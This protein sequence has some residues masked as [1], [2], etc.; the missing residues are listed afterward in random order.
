[1]IWRRLAN[2]VPLDN[3]RRAVRGALKIRPG[4]IAELKRE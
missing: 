2:E 4:R 1:V 3:L